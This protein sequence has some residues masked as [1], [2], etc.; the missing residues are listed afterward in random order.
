[1]KKVLLSVL[2]GTLALTS[3]KDMWDEDDKDS[4]RQACMETAN[5]WAKNDTVAKAYCNCVLGKMIAKY[6]FESEALDHMD[7]LMKDTALLQCK[8]E[9][10]EQYHLK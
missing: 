5:H 7:E 3:C 10:I 9:I 4:F 2:L 8:K 1:M 6:P